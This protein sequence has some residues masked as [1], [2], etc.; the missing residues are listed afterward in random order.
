MTIDNEGSIS[1]DSLNTQQP[2]EDD[3]AAGPHPPRGTF[4]ELMYESKNCS[5]KALALL[6]F[7]L[8][9]DDGSQTFNPVVLPWSAALWSTTLKMTANELRNKVVRRT[10]AAENDLNAHHPKQ[11]TVA[12]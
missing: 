1:V 10:A 2:S 11:W 12:R 3:D 6:S 4:S 8:L 9:N 5:L 7:G